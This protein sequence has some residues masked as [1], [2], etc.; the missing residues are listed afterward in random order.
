MELDVVV[1]LALRLRLVIGL[2]RLAA[3]R[4]DVLVA[5]ALSPG[6]LVRSRAALMRL[7]VLGRSDLLLLRHGAPFVGPT[8]HKLDGEYPHFLPHHFRFQSLIVMLA[9]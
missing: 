7:D 5:L 9:P 4:L 1:A 6:L 3:M 2:E 8:C